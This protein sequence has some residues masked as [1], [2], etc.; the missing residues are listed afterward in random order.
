[1][2][3]GRGVN[4]FSVFYNFFALK[5]LLG[6]EFCMGGLAKYGL[7]SDIKIFNPRHL[8]KNFRTKMLIFCVNT[9]GANKIERLHIFIPNFGIRL[10]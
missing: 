4:P 5:Y 7:S 9:F 1:M 6:L 10:F 3:E 2:G 8:K